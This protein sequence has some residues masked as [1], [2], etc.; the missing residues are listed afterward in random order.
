[1]QHEIWLGEWHSNLPTDS[2]H[3]SSGSAM[4]DRLRAQCLGPDGRFA[5]ERAQSADPPVIG[6]ERLIDDLDHSDPLAAGYA[7]LKGPRGFK[8]AHQRSLDHANGAFDVVPLAIMNVVP[9]GG[10][11][12]TAYPRWRP[13]RVLELTV[14]GEQREPAVS[15]TGIEGRLV[16]LDRGANEAV[17][18]GCRRSDHQWSA[19][20]AR[21]CRGSGDLEERSSAP[22]VSSR[23]QL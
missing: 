14:I 5:P 2:P 8:S 6:E 22:S 17:G 15:V 10:K 11:A 16:A 9:K 3:R 23:S 20:G 7:E 1:M 21:S 19:R 13:D 12:I 4:S 18:G